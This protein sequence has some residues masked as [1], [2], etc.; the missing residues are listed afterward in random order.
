ML[1]S[2]QEYLQALREG[3]YLR[4]LGWPQFIAHHYTMKNKVL[5]ADTISNLLI[6]DWLNNGF[7]ESDVRHVVILIAL[8]LSELRPFRGTLD[9]NLA[10]IEGAA[11]QCLVYQN[12]QL[13]APILSDIVLNQVQINQLMEKQSELC[14]RDTFDNYL[15][16]E[17]NRFNKW[18]SKVPVDLVKEVYQRIIPIIKP[19]D[20]VDEYLD[21]IGDERKRQR[22]DH[23]DD[24]PLIDT[25]IVV[26]HR[27]KQ[28]INEQY[29]LSVEVSQEIKAYIQKI[30][31]MQP[32]ASEENF[33]NNLSMCDSVAINSKDMSAA[34]VDEPFGHLKRYAI[35]FFN[36]LQPPEP[37]ESQQLIASS[38]T[39]PAMDLARN[40]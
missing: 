20:F 24:D 26:I 35:R 12:N 37:S 7:C 32:A 15:L 3:N 23:R 5:D 29:E 18:V 6:F 13:A 25:R 10:C 27:L 16:I 39:T 30:R 4:F 40:S 9:Y 38:S 19:R 17:M 14:D 2:S 34:L 28:Y 21:S 31:K 8:Q 33:L 22:A 36:M 1:S 11:Q